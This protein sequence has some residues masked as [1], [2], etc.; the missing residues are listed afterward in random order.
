MIPNEL[1]SST[2]DL[3]GQLARGDY[4]SAVGRCAKSR[5]SV[6][7]LRSAI[8]EYGRTLVMPPAEAYA[9]LDAVQ[10]KSAVFPTWSVRAP[11]WTAE[12]GRSDL[13]L[14]LTI[15]LAAGEPSIELDDLRVP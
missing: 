10:V 4:Q 2:R 6:D 11:L 8:R 12:E 15:T 5:L 13:T 3:I 1:K 9:N 7:D 14:E